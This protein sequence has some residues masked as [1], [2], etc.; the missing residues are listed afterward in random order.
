M[1][2]EIF[3][4][5]MRLEIYGIARLKRKTLYMYMCIQTRLCTITA[6]DQLHETIG[7]Y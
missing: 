7:C 3:P 5:I 4:I 6:Q 2:R 1:F